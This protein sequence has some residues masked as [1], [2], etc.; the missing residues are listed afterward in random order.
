MKRSDGDL[1]QALCW[2]KTA[3]AS[4]EAPEDDWRD[5]ISEGADSV[6]P[7]GGHLTI[8]WSDPARR[9]RTATP[10]CTAHELHGQPG[11]IPAAARRSCARRGPAAMKKEQIDKPTIA[12]AAGHGRQ[13]P[14]ICTR[15]RSP[16]GG[17]GRARR[18]ADGARSHPRKS[19]RLTSPV[20]W[21]RMARSMH[22][23]SGAICWRGKEQ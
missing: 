10:R 2:H 21:T 5:E 18:A 15:E 22:P 6:P 13:E 19:S 9:T 20:R 12:R 1:Q 17:A 16:R 11:G 14:A 7:I 23:P 4:H 8:A 3:G